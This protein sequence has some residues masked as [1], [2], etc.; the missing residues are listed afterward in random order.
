MVIN[1][2]GIV[3]ISGKLGRSR[4]RSTIHLN[5]EYTNKILMVIR[6]LVFLSLR[7]PLTTDGKGYIDDLS[8]K[9]EVEQEHGN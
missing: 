5:S 8:V 3:K 6:V 1:F 2:E 9:Y 7:Y 4:D